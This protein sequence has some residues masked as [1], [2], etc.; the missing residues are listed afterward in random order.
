MPTKPPQADWDGLWRDASSN[1]SWLVPSSS[2]ID[3]V[4][5]ALFD[6]QSVR[7]QLQ[8]GIFVYSLC[9]YLQ[10]KL[11]GLSQASGSGAGRSASSGKHYPNDTIVNPQAQSVRLQGKDNWQAFLDNAKDAPIPHMFCKYHLNV[12]C[13]A[14]CNYRRSSHVPLNDEQLAALPSWIAKCK[15]KMRAHDATTTRAARNKN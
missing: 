10:A 13:V 4:D 14:N 3:L 15:S 1:T 8:D 6:F 11:S 5:S 7:Q 9:P 2:H 12:R